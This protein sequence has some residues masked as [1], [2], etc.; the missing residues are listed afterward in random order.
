ME[1]YN[2]RKNGLAV[3]L[4]SF[5]LLNVLFDDLGIRWS[6]SIIVL[7]FLFLID[8]LL[9][10]K[11]YLTKSTIVRNYSLVVSS[12]LVM[13]FAFD[14]R[15]DLETYSYMIVLVMCLLLLAFAQADYKQ[16]ILI[17]KVL[18]IT[19]VAFSIYVTLM[20]LFPG[21]YQVVLSFLPSDISEYNRSLLAQGY[22]ASVGGSIVYVDYMI[23]MVTIAIVGLMMAGVHGDLFKKANIKYKI[24]I[25]FAIMLLAMLMEGRRGEPVVLIV[26]ILLMSFTGFN[27]ESS[28]NRSRKLII[29]FASIFGGIIGILVLIRVGAGSRF[30]STT[31][32]HILA[33]D[34][35]NGRVHR[36][37]LAIN[38]FKQ[39]PIVG[40]GWGRF[41]NYYW[42]K[43]DVISLLNIY[44]Y[45]H[46]DFLN[47]LCETGIVGF[48]LIYIPLLRILLLTIKHTKYLISQRRMGMLDDPRRLAMCYFC[49][50]GQY[51]WGILAFIEP[52]LY[53]QMFLYYFTFILI[54]LKTLGPDLVLREKK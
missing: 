14:S 13:F 43:S 35:S 8:T 20:R 2:T 25:V 50:G 4:V 5:I 40:F 42:G 31:I 28:A 19:A 15:K 38:I 53:K 39:Y 48:L 45:V 26:T 21:L 24:G 51:F 34:I 33:G 6:I 1:K 36:W 54:C 32:A 7:G 17:I 41:G 49:L 46:N 37:N 44:K 47:V 3:V 29:L 9:K 30:V 52:V 11:I 12:I 10:G 16:F 22:G 18:T 23:S 27:R